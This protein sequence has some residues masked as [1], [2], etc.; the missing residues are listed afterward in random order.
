MDDK[1]KIVN[2]RHLLMKDIDEKLWI[3]VIQ[4]GRNKSGELYVKFRVY[5]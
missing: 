4:G 3:A 5:K 1:I 2:L